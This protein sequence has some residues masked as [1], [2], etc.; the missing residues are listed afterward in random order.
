MAKVK[1]L[2]KC[3][4]DAKNVDIITS[5]PKEIEAFTCDPKLFQQRRLLFIPSLF[6]SLSFEGHEV[7]YIHDF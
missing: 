2:A 5:L 1:L 7:E 4:G 3:G 6:F